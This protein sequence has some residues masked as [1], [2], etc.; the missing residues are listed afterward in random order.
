MRQ[1]ERGCAVLGRAQTAAAYDGLSVSKTQGNIWMHN[2]V[3][4][5]FPQKQDS[6]SVMRTL[7]HCSLYSITNSM[8]KDSAWWVS[9]TVASCKHLYVPTESVTKGSHLH[10]C[11]FASLFK[12]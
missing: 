3:W 9:P 2:K 1:R 10:N 7:T 12:L 6:Q 5:F 4:I 11:R 8:M